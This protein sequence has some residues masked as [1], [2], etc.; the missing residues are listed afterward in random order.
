MIG[1]KLLPE[2]QLPSLHCTVIGFLLDWESHKS[3]KHDRECLTELLER[4]C[5]QPH[6]IQRIQLTEVSW[7][8]DNK[9]FEPKRV[10]VVCIKSCATFSVLV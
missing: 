4:K 10:W 2:S 7:E 5:F 9:G 8:S 3:P 1:N 6:A